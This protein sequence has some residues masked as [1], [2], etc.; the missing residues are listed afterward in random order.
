MFDLAKVCS[1]STP[2]IDFLVCLLTLID[3]NWKAFANLQSN[4]FIA[5]PI[6]YETA[7][8]FFE[9]SWTISMLVEIPAINF[10]NCRWFSSVFRCPEMVKGDQLFRATL[11]VIDNSRDVNSTW[12]SSIK[13]LIFSW[14][15]QM[16]S[17]P[18]R[19]HWGLL[20]TFS[21]M[22]HIV[23]FSQFLPRCWHNISPWIKPKRTDSRKAELVHSN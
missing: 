1:F 22:L 3:K 5:K 13:S 8:F 17:R 18:W 20:E 12:T 21:K 7:G 11:A 16:R 6:E 2:S 15:C 23:R 4:R 9:F 10:K 14:M 19:L